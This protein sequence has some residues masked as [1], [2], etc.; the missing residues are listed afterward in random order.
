MRTIF[1]LMAFIFSTPCL[2]AQPTERDLEFVAGLNQK[3]IAAGR[4]P[5]KLDLTLFE[6]CRKHSIKMSR[7]YLDHASRSERLGASENIAKGNSDAGATFIQWKN[8]K[9]GRGRPT[10]HYANLMNPQWRYIGIACVDG[11]NGQSYWT[12]RGKADP[13]GE[14]I[15]VPPK[16]FVVRERVR[17][18]QNKTV[19]KQTQRHV[20]NQRPLLNAVRHFFR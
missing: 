14:S 10:G 2:F 5:V 8:A 15:E 3:R 11:A 7:G 19:Y 4:S 12:F 17:A 9:D 18:T 16:E 20:S 13:L 6:G 1:V